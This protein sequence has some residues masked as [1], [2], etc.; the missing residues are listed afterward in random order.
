MTLRAFAGKCPG[1]GACGPVGPGDPP[2]AS[3]CKSQ[4][5]ASA[6]KPPPACYSRSRRLSGEG[7]ALYRSLRRHLDETL[8]RLSH[9]LILRF[10]PPVATGGRVPLCDAG[11]EG[12][13][14]AE[15]R[16]AKTRISLTYGR[17]MIRFP[18]MRGGDAGLPRLR[19][20]PGRRGYGPMFGLRRIVTIPNRSTPWAY[21]T[22]M[23]GCVIASF[24]PVI[25]R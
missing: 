4:K 14:L 24:S 17:G 9:R 1:R 8:R 5:R 25:Q 2:A 16:R 13:L 3:C 23:K 21:K 7:L 18:L 19:I 10:S 20:R 15:E 6:P 11:T 12:V 22:R